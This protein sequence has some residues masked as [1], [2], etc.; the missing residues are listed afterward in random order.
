MKYLLAKLETLIHM[1]RETDRMQL[2]IVM[3]VNA[4]APEPVSV[5][6]NI[7]ISAFYAVWF[8]ARLK[9]GYSA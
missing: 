7:A 9:K 2:D 3:F 8:F 5:I 6:R 4:K 1:A